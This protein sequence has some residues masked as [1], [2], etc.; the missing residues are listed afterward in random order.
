MDKTENGSVARITTRRLVTDAM[1]VAMYVVLSLLSINLG[2]MKITLD[3]LP[4]IVGAA[5]FGP[6]DGLLIGLLGSFM[7]QLLTYGLTATTLLWIMP[8]G[9]RGLLIGW[10]AKKNGFSM[11]ARQTVL[12]VC[13]SALLVTTLNTGVMYVD[14]KLY[15]YYSYAYV[16]GA[17]AIRYLAGVLTAVALSA[18]TPLLLRVMRERMPT[19]E[20]PEEKVL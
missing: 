10:Y 19:G 14:S 13:V 12:I 5:L 2:N 6:I 20:K 15:G 1:L 11:T 9:I 7:N 3:S 17:M 16:F 18:V 8:A 4:I